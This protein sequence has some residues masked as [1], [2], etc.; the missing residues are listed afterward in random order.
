MHDMIGSS[1][2]SVL[3]LSLE[4]LILQLQ[5]RLTLLLGPPGAGKTT[6]LKALAGKLRRDKSL[7]VLLLKFA[8][9]P[10]SLKQ[11]IL[12]PDINNLAGRA[13]TR[14]DLLQL[15]HVADEVVQAWSSKPV[16]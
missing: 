7:K 6:L 16:T 4:G 9:I 3:M 13:G 1:W 15:H 14:A 2:L 5:G 12:L 8:G 10:G 11:T